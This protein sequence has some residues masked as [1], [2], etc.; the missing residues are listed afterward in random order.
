MYPEGLRS[1]RQAATYFPEYPETAEV[2]REM[3]RTF[4]DL[5]LGSTG[6]AL[7]PMTAIAL[8]DEFRELTPAGDKG[9]EM[10]R[11]LADRLVQ[12]DLLPRAAALLEDQVRLRLGGVEKARVGA[13]LALVQM[14]DRK[15]NEALAALQNSEES[16]LPE[17]LDAQRRHLR[18]QALAEL[19][20]R[21][22]ALAALEG[23][24]GKDA[25]LIRADIFWKDEDWIR[26]GIVLRRI[27][28][29]SGVRPG[30]PLTEEQATQVLNLAVALTLAG[31]ERSVAKVRRDYG[32]AMD[33]TPHGEAFRLIANPGTADPSQ[34]RTVANEVSEAEGFQTYLAAFRERLD[35][36]PISAIN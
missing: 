1:L 27:I 18:A 35:Q 22:L 28:A 29:A 12:V 14:L 9:N 10:I 23:D 34:F 32:E 25:D 31:N 26:S 17:E 7:P 15:P 30:T 5:Y 16:D 11:K 8:Y 33:A 24:D 36:T 2:T 21:D 20:R 3:A 19:G 6:E 13:R 4:E